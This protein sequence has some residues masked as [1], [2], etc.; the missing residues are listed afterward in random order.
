MLDTWMI[1]LKEDRETYLVQPDLHPELYG[2]KTFYRIAVNLA[3]TMQGKVFLYPHRLPSDGLKKVPAWMASHIKAVTLGKQ[4]WTRIAWNDETKQH[5][6]G[7]SPSQKIPVWPEN[8]FKELLRIGFKDYV[9]D[10]LDHPVLR[11]LRGE[12]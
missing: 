8:S 5:D 2:E 10:T 11:A 3:V 9:I 7:T 1:E 6:V 12:D 4:A